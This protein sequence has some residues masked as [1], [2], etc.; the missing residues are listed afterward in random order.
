MDN[1]DVVFTIQ[2]NRDLFKSNILIG[3][4]LKI[5]NYKELFKDREL[6][7]ILNNESINETIDA[8]T[9]GNLNLTDASTKSYVHRN[10]LI[11]RI[12]KVKKAIGLDFRNFEDCV[13]YL[14]MRE[15]YRMVNKK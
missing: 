6:I 2:E 11:Y 4:D 5:K 15:I 7:K 13:I 3:K 14:N 9:K 8:F 1:K 12:A 10:T